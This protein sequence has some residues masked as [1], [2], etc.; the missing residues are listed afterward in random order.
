MRGRRTA[1]GRRW[2]RLGI[3]SF[4]LL[5]EFGDLKFGQNPQ[6]GKRVGF[7][8]P[9]VTARRAQMEG[10]DRAYH[11]ADGVHSAAVVAAGHGAVF[12]A[13]LAL[14]SISSAASI[15]QCAAF[16]RSSTM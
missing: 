4:G 8:P 1:G 15:R 9:P 11:P 3:V 13:P 12:H 2:R 16:R 6:I 10:A 7:L 5:V 14:L